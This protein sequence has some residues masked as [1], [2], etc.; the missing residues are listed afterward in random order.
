[1]IKKLSLLIRGVQD[2]RAEENFRKIEQYINRSLL[3]K[4]NS[5]ESGGGDNPPP[6]V[7]GKTLALM[8]IGHSIGD[9][10]Y[11]DLTQAQFQEINGDTW[12]LANGQNCEGT[13]YAKF[14][15]RTTTPNHCGVVPRG[16]NH[17][18]ADAYANPDELDLGTCQG[19]AIRNITGSHTNIG[20]KTTGENSASGAFGIYNISQGRGNQSSIW[21]S[22]AG[23]N[24]DASRVVPT[25]PENRMR[26]IT[27][28]VFIKVNW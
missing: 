23:Y 11:S 27:V 1:M 18:R 26:N 16:K 7:D 21:G 6:K 2:K 8:G 4:L 10:R 17:G 12:V 3:N 19:D 24:F 5:L 28:N 15:G 22:V 25:A 13:D 20:G 9:Y 14:T